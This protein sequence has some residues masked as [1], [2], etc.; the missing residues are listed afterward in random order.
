[1]LASSLDEVEAEAEA[2]RLSSLSEGWA[3]CRGRK[4]GA[5]ITVA[6]PIEDRDKRPLLGKSQ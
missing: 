4:K 5:V 1:M 2:R 6:E 3:Y